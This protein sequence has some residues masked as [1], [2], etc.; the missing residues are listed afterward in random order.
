M[1]VLVLSSSFGAGHNRVAHSIEKYF[2]K[3][4]QIEEINVFDVL[5]QTSPKLN[6]VIVDTYVGML[7]ATPTIY[8]QLYKRAEKDTFIMDVGKFSN[9]IVSRI[10][11]KQFKE[12]EPD[13][14]IC[15]HPFA[16]DVATILKDKYE[17][18]DYRIYAIFTD[19]AP[20]TFWLHDKTDGYI[21]ANEDL[22]PEMVTR[23]IER[24]LI[25]PI[26]IPVDLVFEEYIEKKKARENLGLKD[27][28]T[29]LLM[30]GSLGLG[31]IVDIFKQIVAWDRNIQIIVIAGKNKRLFKKINEID[32]NGKEVKLFGFLDN[33]QEYMS[34]SDILLTKPGGITIAEAITKTL[35]IGIISP[36]PG[37]E[38]RNTNYLL[39]SGLAFMI[40]KEEEFNTIGILENVLN[41]PNRLDFMRKMALEKRKIGSVQKLYELILDE[42]KESIK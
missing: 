25:H 28:E 38:I 2:S 31:D 7:K 37:Q 18:L 23:K 13:V 1:K 41:S 9:H 34:A 20:H 35:P 17:E 15:T 8:E 6:K 29:I 30:G 26:G 33:I 14:V 10:L 19:F 4:E 39:N 40:F 24:K 36:L 11:L 3:Q 27:M 5:N 42:Y 22:I 21:V 32:A 16:L 12:L